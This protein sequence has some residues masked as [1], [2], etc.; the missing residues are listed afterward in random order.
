MR[1]KNLIRILFES[2]E[3]EEIRDEF[4]RDRVSFLIG[5]FVVLILSRVVFLA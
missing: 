3:S 5:V 4:Y 2:F 1:I